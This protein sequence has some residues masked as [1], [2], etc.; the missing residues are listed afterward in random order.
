MGDNYFCWCFN[1]QE[2][3]G[4]K[5]GMGEE[6][7]VVFVLLELEVVATSHWAINYSSIRIPSLQ[8]KS[9]GD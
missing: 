4:G 7:R 3:F 2:E 1:G 9:G 8:Q 5:K 6:G